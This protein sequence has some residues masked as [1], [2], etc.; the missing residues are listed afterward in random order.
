MVFTN[1]ITVIYTEL[2]GILFIRSSI[3]DFRFTSI[4]IDHRK[5]SGVD[6]IRV[7]DRCVLH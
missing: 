2:M 6:S 3:L 7:V 5:I 4:N 1:K